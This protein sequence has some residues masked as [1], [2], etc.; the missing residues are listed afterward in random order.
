MLH[1]PRRTLQEHRLD[2]NLMI[3]LPDRP[4]KPGE[5]LSIV[6]YLAPNSS[7]PSSPSLEHF[8]LR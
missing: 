2:S 5:V 3:R 1:L 6:L 8:T 7:S 4:L